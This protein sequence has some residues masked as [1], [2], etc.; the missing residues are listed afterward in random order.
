MR[1][2]IVR[3]TLLAVL[4]L[5]GVTFVA[6]YLV[7]I[8]GNPV[9]ALFA[10]SA[11]TAAERA[12]V[13][14]SLGLNRPIPVQY[15][16]FL[17]GAFHGDLGDSL[18]LR[19]PSLGVV[20]ERL[21]ATAE[22]A[23]AAL[24][25]SLAVAIPVAVVAAARPNGV[26]DY[27]GR[28]ITLAGQSIPL[29]WLGVMAILVFSVNLRWFPAGGDQTATSIILPAVT[30]GLYPMARIARILRTRLLEETH[31]DYIVTARAKGAGRY[32]TLLRHAM[33]NALPPV[34]TVAGLQIGALLGGA[35]ITE[36]IFNWPG[37]GLLTVQ[38]IEWRDLTLVRA[39]VTVSATIFVVVNLLTDLAYAYVDPRIRY[40]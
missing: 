32:R 3:R 5:A 12:Q 33:K 22:L 35:V 21:P 28:F 20:L 8:S 7:F 19:E 23:G 38:A 39:I 15:L 1:T 17:A 18:R 24:L 25:V 36:T 4:V 37:V 9:N 10:G 16:A 29:Y 34:I 14:Q 13:S 26:W 30:L 31:R 2:F 6:T 27:V 11:T 40:S